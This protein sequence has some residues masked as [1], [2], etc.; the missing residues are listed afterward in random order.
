MG[1]FGKNGKKATVTVTLEGTDD[2]CKT[3]STLTKEI[4][5]KPGTEKAIMQTKIIYAVERALKNRFRDVENN[6]N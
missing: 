3:F 5:F 1:I 2:S 6:M 4:Y